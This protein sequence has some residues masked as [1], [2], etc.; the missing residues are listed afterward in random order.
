MNNNPKNKNIMD[1]YEQD[2]KFRGRT[3]SGAEWRYGSL[4]QSGGRCWILQPKGESDS[5][6]SAVDPRSVGLATG[7]CDNTGK[8]IYEND[9]LET[10]VGRVVHVM[11]D[12][13]GM[14]FI[15]VYS[16]M[17][18]DEPFTVMYDDY[19]PRNLRVV[20]NALKGKAEEGGA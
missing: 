17:Q 16:D 8:E 11:L 6:I 12:R 18:N 10:G 9:I 3:L 5:R 7:L 15:A 1:R 4:V 2:Y 20:G 13:K 14:E 19:G